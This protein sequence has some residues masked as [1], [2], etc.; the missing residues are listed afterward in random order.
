[1]S[2]ETQTGRRMKGRSRHFSSLVSL[3]FNCEWNTKVCGIFNQVRPYIHFI[4]WYEKQSPAFLFS[5]PVFMFGSEVSLFVMEM[6]IWS[7]N[8]C[9]KLWLRRYSWENFKI[10]FKFKLRD[11]QL[12]FAF[13]G[14]IIHYCWRRKK[15]VWEYFFVYH[16]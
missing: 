15:I 13:W 2:S 3:T 12:I 10:T 9:F 1:M 7:L 4:I 5:F 16:I 8:K 6:F 14:H 11:S